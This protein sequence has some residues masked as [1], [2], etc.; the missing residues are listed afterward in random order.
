M[1]TNGSGRIT[2][3]PRRPQ[4][5]Y[6][7][8]RMSITQSELDRHLS[9]IFENV[10]TSITLEEA[11]GRIGQKF[12]CDGRVYIHAQPATDG[13]RTMMIASALG[14]ETRLEGSAPSARTY[15]IGREFARH[16]RLSDAE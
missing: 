7:A 9:E 6:R 12:G 5:T 3:T 4:E 2:R 14:T 10:D 8:A 11:Q 1:T 13:T 15:V 16:I